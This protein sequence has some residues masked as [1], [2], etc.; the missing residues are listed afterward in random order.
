MA[1]GH[2]QSINRAVLV[3]RGKEPYL[4]WVRNLPDPAEID[5]EELN[6]ECTVYL[7]PEYDYEEEIPGIVRNVFRA[8]FENELESWWLN[9][10]DW[11]DTTDFTL[12]REWF[13]V[14]IHSV[15]LD[16]APG[17]VV[18]EDL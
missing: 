13:E 12:F 11:P 3:A 17:P 5:L 18:L 2:V 16:L 4:E 1:F 8:I 9:T 6:R 10:D 14:E 7:I 15:A